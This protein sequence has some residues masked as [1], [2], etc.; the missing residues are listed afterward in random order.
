[1]QTLS[2]TKKRKIGRRGDDDSGVKISS[3]KR[4]KPTEERPQL[5]RVAKLQKV[6][7]PPRIKSLKKVLDTPESVSSAADESDDMADEGGHSWIR[8]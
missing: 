1:M 7:T 8:G 2:I 4:I 3:F 5:Y 6:S